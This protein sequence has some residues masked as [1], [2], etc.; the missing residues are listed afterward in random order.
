MA[1]YLSFSLAYS[2][3]FRK[4]DPDRYEFANE[5]FLRG[6]KHLLKNISRRKSAQGHGQQPA[7]LQS[8]TV[9]ACVEVGKYGLEEEVEILKQDKNI[10]MQELV[11]L[12]QQQQATDRQLQT[13]GQRVQV[14]EQRQQ[15]MM[16]F[17]AKAMHSP[18]FLSQLVQQQNDSNRRISGGNKKRR[19]PRQDEENVAGAYNAPNGQIIKFQPSMNEA[20]KAMLHQISKMN[21]S[22][23]LEPSMSNLGSFLI[24]NVASANTLDSRSSSSQ[25]SGVTLAE[26]PPTSGQSY[27]SA[28]SRFPVSCPSSAMSEIKGPP[29]VATDRVKV[30]KIREM[31]VH[32]AREDATLRNSQLPGIVPESTIGIP[33]VNFVMCENGSAENMDPIAA[34][35]DGSMP[36]E[37]DVF[38]PDQDG[39]ILPDGISK[40]PGIDD[41]FWE[42]F[43]T[44]SPLTGD[45]DEINSSSLEAGMTNERELQSGQENGWD[46]IQHLNHLTE[47]MG[48]LA[49][50]GRRL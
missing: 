44:A 3:G 49:S 11:R 37:A 50:E 14:M 46:K 48:L 1:C 30:D 22:S 43:L 32:S 36:V 40:L 23:R 35:L 18:G 21:A 19:L 45:T 38:S 6:Q 20:A 15:Q 26:V 41:V 34:V 33:D 12:R 16:S 31:N 9:G 10:L 25:I 5:G 8:S 47:Q 42:Q 29:C 13:V 39:D 17:L 4:V 27:M 2:E 24:D 7:Q 28:E